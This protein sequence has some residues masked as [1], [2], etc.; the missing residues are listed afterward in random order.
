MRQ[1]VPQASERRVCRALGISGTAVRRRS[2]GW[3]PVLPRLNPA[4]TTRLEALIQRYATFGYR[5]LWA[6]LRFR[7]GCRVTPKTVYRILAL[8]AGSC[9]NGP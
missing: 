7:E 3:T 8:K 4:L 6:W 5:R 9:T 2:T 1:A